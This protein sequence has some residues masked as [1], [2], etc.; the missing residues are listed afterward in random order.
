MYGLLYLLLNLFLKY[1]SVLLLY[2]LYTITVRINIF[3]LAFICI[4][5]KFRF[6]SFILNML[7]FIMFNDNHHY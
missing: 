6:S 2:Y 7:T 4:S 5:F 3:T 1:W